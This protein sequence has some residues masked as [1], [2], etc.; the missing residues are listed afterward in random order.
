MFYDFYLLLKNPHLRG[1]T[2]RLWTAWILASAVGWA[3]AGLTGL[4]IGRVVVVEGG[5][6]AIL[7]VAA[8]MSLIGALVGGL[9]GASQALFFRL[10]GAAAPWWFA[11]T[12]VGWG[13]G[14]P[15]ALVANL[16]FGLGISA[17]L[18][19]LF[20]GAGAG[21]AQAIACRQVV[22][23]RIRWLLATLLAYVLAISGAGWLELRLLVAS[24]GAWG[25]AAWQG[26]ITG[27]FAGSIAGAISGIALAIMHF[28]KDRG[29][30]A[31][32]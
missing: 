20:V 9:I 13:L 31:T 6:A 12:A 2:L 27:A 21:L 7:S 10:R 15:V 1:R 32:G 11:A 30:D 17:G 19:G 23:D 16:L 29:Q 5:T 26:S 4:P 8:S 3:A 28:R 18:Y 24:N 25:A 22:P 14:L